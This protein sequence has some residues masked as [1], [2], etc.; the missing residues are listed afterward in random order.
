MSTIYYDPDEWEVVIEHGGEGPSSWASYQQR[1][2]SPEAIAAIKALKRRAHE[3]A[4]LAEAERIRAAR[5]AI[6]VGT[7]GTKP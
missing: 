3:D 1:R 6:P 7:E 2:R 4:V 5:A